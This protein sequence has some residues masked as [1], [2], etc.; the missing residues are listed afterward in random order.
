MNPTPRRNSKTRPSATRR[1]QPAALVLFAA[2]LLVPLAGCG[3]RGPPSPPGPS[4]QV[5]YPKI[6][7]TQ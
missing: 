7:P 5:T 1:W 4:S 3:K 6:Y 2:A